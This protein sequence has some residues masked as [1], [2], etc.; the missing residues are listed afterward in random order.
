MVGEGRG[1]RFY[2]KAT[3][4]PHS[5]WFP[6]SKEEGGIVR[7]LILE[8]RGGRLSLSGAGAKTRRKEGFV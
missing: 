5:D 8:K 3:R 2:K 1:I 6:S 7:W 4:M